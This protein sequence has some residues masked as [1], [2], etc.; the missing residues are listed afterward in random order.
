M[1][2]GIS[3]I[4]AFSLLLSGQV[5][6][7]RMQVSF[8]TAYSV[9]N[10]HAHIFGIWLPCFLVMF[11][12]FIEIILPRYSVL[13]PV[14]WF[15]LLL[16]RP[17]HMGFIGLLDIRY[18]LFLVNPY[19]VFCNIM[20]KAAKSIANARYYVIVTMGIFPT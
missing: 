19:K 16:F 17:P 15:L 18:L 10:V 7:Y 14:H 12:F 3:P 6:R 4:S 11:T 20:V 8:G 5:N 9:F 13:P 2:I 1:S